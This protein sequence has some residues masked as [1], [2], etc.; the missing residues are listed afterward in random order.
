[1]QFYL[2]YLELIGRFK[3]IGLPFCYPRVSAR[4]KEIAAEETFDLALAN[5]LV[6]EGGGEATTC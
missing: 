2:A 1:M 6:P 5:R 4:S 3:A